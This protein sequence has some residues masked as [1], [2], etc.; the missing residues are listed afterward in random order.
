MEYPAWSSVQCISLV[1]P[2]SKCVC[3]RFPS[4]PWRRNRWCDGSHLT[5]EDSLTVTWWPRCARPW[6][7][8][9]TLRAL[10]TVAR[11][12]QAEQRLMGPPDEEQVGTYGENPD[13]TA[14]I[15]A[16]LSLGS[17][18]RLAFWNPGGELGT[19]KTMFP[20]HGPP[21]GLLVH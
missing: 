13:N 21:L 10:P 20:L 4:S 6:D 7:S 11:P 14:E 18:P 12:S 3:F 2:C 15:C 19:W 8:C 16:G 5:A 17:Q 1:F 9:P